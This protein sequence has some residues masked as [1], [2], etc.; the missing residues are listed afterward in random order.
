MGRLKVGQGWPYAHFTDEEREAERGTGI[1]KATE[2]R[3]SGFWDLTRGPS[4]LS[5]PGLQ[6]GRGT[7]GHCAAGR[8]E[9]LAPEDAP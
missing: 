5:P 8:D 7:R 1:G 3:D 4:C 6:A 2:P 9:W